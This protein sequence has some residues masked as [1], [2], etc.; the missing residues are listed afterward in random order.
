MADLHLPMTFNPSPAHKKKL[1]E[2]AALLDPEANRIYVAGH[3]RLKLFTHLITTLWLF[4]AD[5]FYD[6]GLIV[7][8]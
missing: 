6:S 1:I 7:R 3:G 2:A 5:S 8:E 4:P